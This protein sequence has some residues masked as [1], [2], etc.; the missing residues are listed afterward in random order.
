MTLVGVMDNKGLEF[1]CYTPRLNVAPRH[2]PTAT[3]EM[4][5]LGIASDWRVAIPVPLPLR[6][7]RRK[8]SG[9]AR[10]SRAKTEPSS[11]TSTRRVYPS[12]M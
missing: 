12:R 4:I 5:G 2:P 6:L 11:I 1:R 7:D 8:I 10:I 3:A 9:N